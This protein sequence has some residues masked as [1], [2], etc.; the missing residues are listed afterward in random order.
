MGIDDYLL[1]S[2]L[3]L[4]IGQRL[5]RKL[6]E[7]CREPYAPAAD[8]RRR[9]GLDLERSLTW[10]RPAGCP[11]CQGGYKG[12]TTIVEALPMTD[13]VR[14]KVL[15]RCDAHQIEQVAISAGMRTM[16]AHGIERVHA[17]LTTAE[18]VLRVT[19]LS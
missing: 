9:F 8:A 17:G 11:A 19:N 14:A 3:H 5:V 13:A 10:Y 2:T 4:I 6:C 18:E 15:A 7:R 1:T 12:R 16:F